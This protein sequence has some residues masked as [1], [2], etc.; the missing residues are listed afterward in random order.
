LDEDGSLTGKGAN[1]IATGY[2]KQHEQK[3]CEFTTEYKDN[4]NNKKLSYMPI[5]CDNTVQV[6]RVHFH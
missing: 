2:Y 5:M 1:S 4:G 6:R 3:E